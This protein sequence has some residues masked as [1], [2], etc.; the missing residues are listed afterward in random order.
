[1]VC[2]QMLRELIPADLVKVQSA[3]EWKRSIIAAYNQDAGTST[4]F[5]T[6]FSKPQQ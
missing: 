4:L 5:L 1:M 3:N 6:I 2:R